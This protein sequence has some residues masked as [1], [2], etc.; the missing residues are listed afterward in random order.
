[1]DFAAGNHNQYMHFYCLKAVLSLFAITWVTKV[2]FHTNERNQYS[3]ISITAFRSICS[4][5]SSRDILSYNK[6][7]ALEHVTQVL[8]K[9]SYTRQSILWLFQGEIS[10]PNSLFVSIL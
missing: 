5:Q 4:E 10:L 2:Y 3:I 9:K 6:A 1:M 8:N 7:H